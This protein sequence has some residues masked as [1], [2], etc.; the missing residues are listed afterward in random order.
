VNRRS[1]EPSELGL[2]LLPRVLLRLADWVDAKL[3][4]KPYALRPLSFA[5]IRVTSSGVECRESVKD[6]HWALPA[7]SEVPWVVRSR[8]RSDRPAELLGR[9]SAD[10]S[11]EVLVLAR[12][13]ER[14]FSTS[15]ETLAV[16]HGSSQ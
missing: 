2:L 5:R 3:S 7:E 1:K 12:D 11:G 9:R 14:S 8:N 13:E 15:C 16:D 10:S 4:L 6:S